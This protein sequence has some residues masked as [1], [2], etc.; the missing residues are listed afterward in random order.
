MKNRRLKD[1]FTNAFRGIYQAFKTENNIRL[2]VV[3]AIIVIIT[4]FILEF[5]QIEWILV[6]VVIIIVIVTE[7]LN[8]AVEYA[9]DM[10]CGNEYNEI[11]KYAKD[12]AAGATLIAACGA[13]V[14]GVILYLPKMINYILEIIL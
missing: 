10:V 1:S 2:H 5:S 13:F 14:I 12:I 9:I 8:T 4:A 11:A 3:S 7:I 6:I